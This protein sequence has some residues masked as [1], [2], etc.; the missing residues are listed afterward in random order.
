MDLQIDIQCYQE[1]SRD[2]RKSSILQRFLTDT[3][4]IDRASKSV[5]GRSE[6]NVR[7]DYK[8]GGTGTVW[9][10][11]ERQQEE[12]YNKDL[13]TWEGGHGWHSKDKAIKSY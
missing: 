5:W 2:T 7:N 4:K 1:V 9:L 12:E 6:I 8:P 11:S 10:R 13:M 3:K